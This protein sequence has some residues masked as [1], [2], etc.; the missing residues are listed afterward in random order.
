[1]LKKNIWKVSIIKGMFTQKIEHENFIR[2]LDEVDYKTI[3]ENPD[4]YVLNILE[5]SNT[6]L[7]EHILHNDKLIGK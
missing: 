4:A 1:M 7:T 2:K 3:D 5:F 6:W